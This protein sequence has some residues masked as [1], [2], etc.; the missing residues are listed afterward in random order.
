MLKETEN[1]RLNWLVAIFLAFIFVI[2][3]RLYNLQVIHNQF[4]SDK[5]HS[6]RT[7]FIRDRAQRGRMVDR[8]GIQL[9]ATKPSFSLFITPEDFPGDRR[10][11]VYLRLSRILGIPPSMIREK[12]FESKTAR[13]RPR[14]IVGNL[15]QEQVVRIETN[16]YHLPGVTINAENVRAYPYKTSLCHV[17]GYVGEISQ[18]Q[19]ESNEYAGYRIGDIVGQTGIER[20]FESALN[21][22]DGYRWVE[23]DA[24]GRQGFTLQYPAPVQAVPGSELR[25][26]VDLEL[27]RSC[28]KFL[29]PWKGCI[30]VMDPR[31]GDV[32]ALVSRPGYD[33]NWF[34]SG[35]SLPLWK[36]IIDNPD[37][38]LLNRALQMEAPPGSIFKI[39]T[40]VAAL[41]SPG[42][43]KDTTLFCNGVFNFS[44]HLFH[45]WNKRGHGNVNLEGALEGSCNVFFYQAG[46]HAGID[47][48][49]ET[50]RSFGL[51][52]ITGIA[53]PGEQAGFIPDRQ[54][55]K[56]TFNDDWWPGETISVSI[57]QGGVTTTPIQLAVMMAMIANRGILYEPR[58]VTGFMG[59][60]A[61]E[62]RKLDPVVRSRV[63]RFTDWDMIITGLNRV[64]AGPNGTARR[65]KMRE[66]TVAGKTGTAQVISAQALKRLGYASEAEVDPRF[67]DHNWFAGFGPV[68]SPEVVVV[69]L[70]EN[71]GKTGAQKKFEVAKKVF[72][73]WYE[74]NRPGYFGPEKEHQ[75]SESSD[76]V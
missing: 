26:T 14:K 65:L 42:F 66:M 3:I 32:L 40:A 74:L 2:A 22:Q 52:Q 7:R 70:L 48:I 35:I 50:A 24:T 62:S 34:V 47:L 17:L 67:W 55:K 11:G 15:T 64:V 37:N 4:Y 53:L 9:A 19:L 23:V 60:T 44:N 36:S 63:T 54:W 73:R 61:R 69:V 58:L 29:T 27:Q 72:L 16:R 75:R 6:N 56:K 49:A 20:T 68:E 33:P 25:L 46:I 1:S 28:E 5:A 13:F 43:N 71:G 8:N 12:Y 57:G 76:N 45:C 10:D 18:R 38:P 41:C 31:N 51:G 59:H 30:I 21:G 39:I